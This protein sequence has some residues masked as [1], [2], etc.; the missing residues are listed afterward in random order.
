[1]CEHILHIHQ[2]VCSICRSP[3]CQ[4][5]HCQPIHCTCNELVGNEL[6]GTMV[7]DICYKRPDVYVK[8]VR[9]NQLQTNLLCK[10]LIL[11][12]P[13]QITVSHG[14]SR[15]SHGCLFRVAT[16]G[17]YI[18]ILNTNCCDFE[19]LSKICS[20]VRFSIPLRAPFR[21]S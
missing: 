8:Y 3:W 17:V 18:D 16:F 7:T 14:N 1:M 11:L 21:C 15:F 5:I 12:T 10:L 9:T 2:D 20:R 19:H 4:A 13:S 6:L